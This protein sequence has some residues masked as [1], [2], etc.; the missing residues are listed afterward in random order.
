MMGRSFSL[1][2]FPMAGPP[3]HL[4]ITGH[5]TRRP[6]GL[7]VRYTLLG[8]PA[9]LVIPHPEEAP[10]RRSELWKGTCFE[11]FL[12]TVDS[13]RYWEF[14]LS[15]AG[16]WNAY[17]FSAYRQGMREESAFTSLPF[18]VISGASSLSH[19]FEIELSLE[20]ELELDKIVQPDQLLEAAVSAVVLHSDGKVTLWALTHPGQKADFHGR[21][22]FIIRL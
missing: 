4:R 2:P 11:L 16:H 13:P 17:R 1:K 15:P 6:G 18:R 5:I 10:A 7:A 19:E 9:G 21:E 8:D 22:S 14:N 3:L 12:A 20:L